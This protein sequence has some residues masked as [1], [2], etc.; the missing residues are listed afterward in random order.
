MEGLTATVMTKAFSSFLLSH[1]P[2]IFSSIFSCELKALGSGFPL[3]S[4][5]VA[6]L[7][8]LT[9]VFLEYSLSNHESQPLPALMLNG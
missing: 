4:M 3:F 9:R 1:V 6:A 2:P 5:S 8:K 7:T